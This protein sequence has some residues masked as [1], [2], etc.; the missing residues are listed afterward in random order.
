MDFCVSTKENLRFNPSYANTYATLY[1]ISFFFFLLSIKERKC[2]P[3]IRRL[4]ESHSRGVSGN[5]NTLLLL[6]SR[7]SLKRFNRSQNI[8]HRLIS[9]PGWNVQPCKA[10]VRTRIYIGKL[11]RNQASSFSLNRNKSSFGAFEEKGLVGGGK[12]GRAKWSANVVGKHSTAYGD[13]V[14]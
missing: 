9:F 14:N 3:S 6:A 10:N 13:P 11:K 2:S 7:R 12:E 8:C 4:R 5:P 1:G